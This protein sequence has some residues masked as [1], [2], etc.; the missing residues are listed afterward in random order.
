MGH[1]KTSCLIQLSLNV[2]I[3]TDL[4]QRQNLHKLLKIQ[5]IFLQLYKCLLYIVFHSLEPQKA[6]LVDVN[7]STACGCQRSAVAAFRK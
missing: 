6:G 4:G 2:A 7:K 5:Q 1:T 3:I